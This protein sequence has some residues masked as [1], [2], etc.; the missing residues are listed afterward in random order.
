M[1]CDSTTIKGFH[2]RA[3]VRVL[4][5]DGTE[6]IQIKSDS[7]GWPSSFETIL[8]LTPEQ[9]IETAKALTLYANAAIVRRA[10]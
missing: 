8:C 6:S 4:G 7:G 2:E 10:V 5:F 3:F 9:A 1:N